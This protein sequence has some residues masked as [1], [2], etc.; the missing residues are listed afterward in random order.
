MK[1]H[2]GAQRM[3]PEVITVKHKRKF[4]TIKDAKEKG[5]NL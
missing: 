2:I 1:K 3:S 5:N 4:S